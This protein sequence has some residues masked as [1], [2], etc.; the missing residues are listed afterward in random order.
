MKR[1]KK[2]LVG[3]IAMVMLVGASMSAFAADLNSITAVS[4]IKL[5]KQ[6]NVTI[7]TNDYDD[8]GDIKT[9]DMTVTCATDKAG[10]VT[11]SLKA[12][13]SNRGVVKVSVSKPAVATA[14]GKKGTCTATLTLTPVA[15]GKATVTV[16]SISNPKK[17]KKIT[18]TVKT[19]ADDVKC[20]AS[21]EGDGSGE[22]PYKITL[23]SNRG[24]KLNLG[25]YVT[26]PN[27]SN[28][29]LK[30]AVDTASRSLI[31]CDAKGNVSVKAKDAAGKEGYVTITSAEK[32]NTK[33]NKRVKVSI[34]NKTPAVTAIKIAPD[35]L[36]K[37]GDKNST[38]TNVKVLGYGRVSSNGKQLYLKGNKGYDNNTY[39]LNCI[40]DA[41]ASMKDLAF[42]S[43]KPAVATVDENGKI[44]AVGNG[45]TTIT[46]TPKMGN[47]AK[48]TLNVTVD[49]DVE[50]VNVASTKFTIL[51]NNKD[52]AKINATTNGNAKN[53]KITYGISSIK[54]E[55]NGT[56]KEEKA[57]KDSK[58]KWKWANS[59]FK[60]AQYITVDA[61]GNV[62]AK[63]ECVATIVA[64]ATDKNKV[65]A[66]ATITVTAEDSVTAL[67]LQAVVGEG[68][69]NDI[70]PTVNNKQHTTKIMAY[71]TG[72]G[73]AE[74]LTLTAAATWLSKEANKAPKVTWTSNKPAVAKVDQNGKV[75]LVGNG[76]AK[77]TANADSGKS[78]ATT[79]T[80]KTDA[81]KITPAV[82]VIKEGDDNVVYVKEFSGKKTPASIINASVN[83]DASNKKITYSSEKNQIEAK[84][85][86][87]NGVKVT[88]AT[89]KVDNNRS[90]K[91]EEYLIKLSNAASDTDSQYAIV[92]DGQT[93]TRLELKA[94]ESCT[95]KAMKGDAVLADA[96]WAS[97]NTKSVKVDKN[98][99]VKAVAET[100]PENVA[101]IKVNDSETIEVVVGRK[102][103]AVQTE[104]NKSF[105][106]KLNEENRDY[107]GVSAKFNEK[108]RAVSMS[109]LNPTQDIKDLHE[110]GLVAAMEEIA[111]NS[112]ANRLIFD[113]VVITD[114]SSKQYT[115][116]RTSDSELSTSVELK[117]ANGNTKEVDSLGAAVA[118]VLESHGSRVQ[119]LNGESYSIALTL[120]Y[121]G[122]SS[123]TYDLVYTADVSMDAAKYDTLVDSKI[124]RAVE[125]FNEKLENAGDDGITVGAGSE[126]ETLTKDMMSV[127]YNPAANEF[128]VTIEDLDVAYDKFN[129]YS[130]KYAN[131]TFDDL[132]NEAEQKWQDGVT[133]DGVDVSDAEKD[134]AKTYAKDIAG[135]L[136]SVTLAFTSS[137]GKNK[138]DT[139][140]KTDE[141][142]NDDESKKE[143][144]KRVLEKYFYQLKGYGDPEVD[145]ALD[146]VADSLGNLVGS[147]ASANATFT[148]GKQTY[149]QSY[150]V[151]FLVSDNAYDKAAD[152]R[153][154]DKVEENKG[155]LAGRGFVV[156]YDDSNRLTVDIK[157][158]KSDI[159]SWE[160]ALDQP[161]T[162]T[163]NMLDETKIVN[164]LN[165][166]LDTMVGYDQ[167]VKDANVVVNGK[168][169]VLVD[170]YKKNYGKVNDD[171]HTTEITTGDA[172]TL[173]GALVEAKTKKTEATT[174]RDMDGRTATLKVT[175]H[176][177]QIDRDVT[178]V[179]TITFSV[180]GAKDT[181]KAESKA[182]S[183]S[184]NS[185]EPVEDEVDEATEDETDETDETGEATED[186]TDETD[187]TDGTDEGENGEATEDGTDGIT[188][189]ETDGAADETDEATEDE[190]EGTTEG[191]DGVA[192]GDTNEAVEG[193][194]GTEIPA[195]VNTEAAQV[196]DTVAE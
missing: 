131:A 146:G 108:S 112:Y 8:N 74:K 53:K 63:K 81:Y 40:V 152:K 111:R 149:T 186:E 122:A 110:T 135:D 49:T 71:R 126:S 170:G 105:K 55:E 22:N 43:S 11:D 34:E 157:E 119:D 84:D 79:V 60:P 61:K 54:W 161:L 25:A 26:T 160:G 69:S 68:Y 94:G 13:S 83:A 190:A 107:T 24:S 86:G 27:A 179:Y 56:E 133:T 123:L 99:V 158:Q 46:V 33:I 89:T 117:D 9:T 75:T 17:T 100:T 174:L 109:I 132:W 116:T 124:Q 106:T 184:D 28:V 153:I 64:E 166:I 177:D 181:P 195:D 80:V 30:Y 115:V 165:D 142:K 87:E 150:K 59:K 41:G 10:E 130:E 101:K 38:S 118:T 32:A 154:N 98:G 47:N 187:E 134:E 163:W 5:G 35:R 42:V 183:I 138:V 137:N 67:T 76:T 114:G 19:W 113:E 7:Y 73:D 50:Y 20:S 182:Q 6:S 172:R 196:A 4:S 168:S 173:L 192:G 15:N 31:S 21:D 136:S 121:Y 37:K 88:V 143:F 125:V 159:L 3:L 65:E 185:V 145:G 58:G 162:V 194:T 39:Q 62:K 171:D 90:N 23:A 155:D 97:T 95:L 193:E 139:V 102:D 167:N 147:V 44:T 18:V 12:I 78:I 176:I 16:A 120:H 1:I 72:S 36:A 178:L 140:N 191:T 164:K 93:I 29:K 103:A 96:Q 144:V 189:D 48:A 129:E 70:K 77:I 104:I 66:S 188:E 148:V 92:R 2:I 151:N 14:S 128:D 52:T 180:E 141:S 169:T 91:S 57:T 156:A 45:K 85:I 51:A 175:Y 82:Q 127:A